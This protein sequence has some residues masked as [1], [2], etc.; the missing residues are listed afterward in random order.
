M[1]TNAWTLPLFVVATLS[2]IYF[3]PSAGEVAQSAVAM[4]LP[5]SSGN[6]SF[7]SIPPSKAEID[8]LSKDTQFAKAICL[9]ARP[10]TYNADG[11]PILDRLDLS[12]VLSGADINNS[13]HRPERCMPAQGH[14]IVSTTDQTL[15]LGNG[16]EFPAKRLIS[17]QNIPT[18]E[19]RTEYLKLNC[20]TY[21]FFVGHDR[22]TNDHLG[23]TLIDMKDRLLRGMDQR[24]AYASVSMWYGKVPWI[25]KEVTEEE[26][27]AKIQTFLADFA[28]KQIAWD[29]VVP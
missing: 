2:G 29:Q 24:W 18:N 27:D 9:S 23:R 21:Y 10:N 17:I 28:E 11:N 13:I 26:A 12:I 19:E 15:K 22:V 5:S 16:R 25:E 1:K 7:R 20:V 8:T 3:L 6:W 4:E 14:S